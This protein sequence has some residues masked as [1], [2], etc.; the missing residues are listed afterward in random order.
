MSKKFIFKSIIIGTVL[1]SACS[2]KSKNYALNDVIFKDPDT[3]VKPGDDFFS[4]A[5]G[6]W[7]KKK[8][9]PPGIPIIGNR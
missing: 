2:N 4:Y 8:S 5:N 1:F 3:S 9:Y 6:G 7:L